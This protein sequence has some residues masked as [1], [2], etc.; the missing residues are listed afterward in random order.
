MK[1]ITIKD[2]DSKLFAEIL[3]DYGGMLT[4][5]NYHG[6]EIIF[7]DEEMLHQS[8]VLAGG[9]PVLFPFPS[10]TQNDEYQ[11]DNV[12]Y[13]M[14]FHGLVKCS[15]FGVD[16][17]TDNSVTLFITNNEASKKDNFPFDFKLNVTYRV[18][19]DTATFSTT[20]HNCSDKPMPHYFGWHHYFTASDKTNFEIVTN[21]KKYIN[22]IDGKQY[23]NEKIDLTQIGDYVFWDKTGNTTEIINPADGY[24]AIMSTD[25]SYEAMVICTLFD[26]RITVE[27]WLGLPN[28]ININKYVKWVAPHQSE[29]YNVTIQLCDYK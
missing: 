23:S 14:P 26:G 27:P 29:T 16:N 12:I 9:C 10:R 6:K 13:S 20:V 17:I 15:P 24:K 18:C 3:P 5:L 1:K 21:M 22:Y 11:I 19:G 8:N 25:D 28:S 4:R 2:T 7:F